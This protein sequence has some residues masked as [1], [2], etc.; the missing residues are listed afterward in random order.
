MNKILLINNLLENSGYSEA[1]R[2][3][4]KA[5]YYS[6]IPIACRNI[7]LTPNQ[8]EPDSIIKKLLEMEASDCDTLI[9][10]SLPYFFEYD[11]RFKKCIGR[12]DFESLTLKPTNWVKKCNLMDEI[13]VSCYWEQDRLKELGVKC[14][15]QVVPHPID[16]NRFNYKIVGKGKIGQVKEETGNYVFYTIGEFVARKN[17]E[18]LL[19]AWHSQFSIYDNAELIIKSHQS[20]RTSDECHQL[21]EQLNQQ[22]IRNLKINP[23][24]VKNP[25]F[26]TEY[27]S[28]AQ[29]DQLH[30]EGDCF[31]ST[32]HGEGHCQPALD[33]TCFGKMTLLPDHSGFL[34]YS[35]GWLIQSQEAPCYGALDTQTDIYNGQ[36]FWYNIDIKNL[37]DSMKYILEGKH[38]MSLWLL[39][40]NKE[41]LAKSYSYESIGGW[42][43]DA[44][45]YK[46]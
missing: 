17:Y 11:G 8:I 27:Y 4:A 9:I 45:N 10:H 36:D 6:K 43:K 30:H 38:D 29:I 28:E 16:I 26:I 41:E 3:L 1:G 7:K 44:L 15:I 40:S 5:C 42:I 31:V 35:G 37:A 20:G 33:A 18:A 23:K 19:K 22:T 46:N 21:F 25:I 39:Q 34:D 13:W 14:P 2:N 32:S 12:F 24:Y